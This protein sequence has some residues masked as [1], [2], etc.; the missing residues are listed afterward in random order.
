MKKNLSNCTLA[1]KEFKRGKFSPFSVGRPRIALRKSFRPK[2][3]FPLI[4]YT[5]PLRTPLAWGTSLMPSDCALS[6]TDTC[7]GDTFA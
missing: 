3:F 2:D 7:P 6:F 5:P 1:K 4:C